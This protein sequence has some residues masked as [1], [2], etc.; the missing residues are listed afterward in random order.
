MRRVSIDLYRFLLMFSIC[1]LHSI[2]QGGYNI[3]WMANLF[4][5]CVPGFV[6]ISGW[7]S[8]K[9]SIIKLI[10]LYG[11]S[12]YCAIVYVFFDL[13]MSGD[14]ERIH[15]ADIVIRCWRIATRQWFL[16]AYA[17][18]VCLAP[19]LNLACSKCV[20]QLGMGWRSA[21][22]RLFLVFPVLFCVW[23]W[24]FATTL[25][26]VGELIPPS[27]GIVAYSSFMMV[28]VYIGAR[29]L[30]LNDDIVQEFRKRYQ[31]TTI[32]LGVICLMCM[33]FGLNDY[34]S[35]FSF[36]FATIA[37]YYVRQLDVPKAIEK[38]LVWLT[39]SMFSIYLIH[40]HGEAWGYL[41]QI[42]EQILNSGKFHIGM[43][44]VTACIIFVISLIMD[45]PRR[46]FLWGIRN[47]FLKMKS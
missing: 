34:N 36:L 33:S 26:I 47:Y 21:M 1:L 37:F 44:L 16:N 31:K 32:L 41:R 28:G 10:K 17:V 8:I 40:A 22:Q 5:W 3:P 38:F 18:L 46:M 45:M 15:T 12:F 11:I 9:F 19:I 6:F 35:P 27:P 42:E 13:F 30:R 4:F 24:S 43:F 39:P 25:P 20:L 23:G 29:L 2:T 7:F 14:F